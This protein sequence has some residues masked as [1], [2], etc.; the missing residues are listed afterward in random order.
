MV[1]EINKDLDSEKRYQMFYE[2]AQAHSARR[3]GAHMCSNGQYAG[4]GCTIFEPLGLSVFYW[5]Q[6]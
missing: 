3:A 4:Q 2:E 1:W 6:T 5:L